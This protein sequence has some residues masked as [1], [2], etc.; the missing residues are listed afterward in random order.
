MNLAFAPGG[1]GSQV[2]R[3]ES[4]LDLF[5]IHASTQ[6]G[7]MSLT[8]DSKLPGLPRHTTIEAVEGRDEYDRSRT[9]R[10]AKDKAASFLGAWAVK[11]LGVNVEVTVVDN[12]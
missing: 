6:R 10:A 1:Y 4:G 3:T 8:L 9:Y 7:N 5:T 11:H 2:G 12:T